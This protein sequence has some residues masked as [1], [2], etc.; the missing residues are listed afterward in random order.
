MAKIKTSTVL[1]LLQLLPTLFAAGRELVRT[2]K[3]KGSSAAS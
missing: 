3:G 1:N 2:I